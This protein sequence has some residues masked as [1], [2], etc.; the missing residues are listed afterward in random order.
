MRPWL[1]RSLATAKDLRWQ[2]AFF[3]AAALVIATGAATLIMFFRVSQSSGWITHTLEVRIAAGDFFS[4]MQDAETGERGYLMT[5]QDR[6]L[7]PYQR[8]VPQVTATLDK[9]RKLT[10]DNSGQQELL[11]KLGPLADARLKFLAE[12]IA[13][14]QGGQKEQAVLLIKEG[15]GK[16]AMDDIRG[17]VAGLFQ[18]ESTLL[19]ARERAEQHARNIL[20]ILI[21][22][23]LAGASV[24]AVMT[25]DS[26][27][28]LSTNCARRPAAGKLLKQPYSNL[29]KW[30]L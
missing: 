21:L 11:A 30:R 20:L 28:S 22:G 5:G 27:R 15:L 6:F 4:R 1:A 13:L 24:L 29:R 10:A 26:Q 19:A 7:E 3:L 8:A 2:P 25:V 23:G 16:A 18:A 9:L 12:M 14:A 17:L